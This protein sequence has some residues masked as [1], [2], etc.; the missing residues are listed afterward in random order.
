[1]KLEVTHAWSEEAPE[2]KL[3]WF[4]QKPVEQRLLEAFQEAVLLQD[5]I[6]Y[7]LPDERASR[8]TVK[9]LER[10]RG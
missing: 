5:L 3:R 9:I 6:Q 10:S 2:A 8:Q 7:E 1:M 4:L